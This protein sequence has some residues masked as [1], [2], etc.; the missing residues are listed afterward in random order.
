MLLALTQGK[1]GRIGN[2][3]KAGSSWREVFKSSEDLLTAAVFGRLVYLRGSRLW[4]ILRNAFGSALPDYKLVELVDASFWPTWPE[5]EGGTK[6]VEPDVFLQF[7]VGDPA[8]R[9]DVIVEAKYRPGYDQYAEQWQ[10]QWTAYHRFVAQDDGASA[11]LLAIGGLGPHAATT[12]HRLQGQLRADGLDVKVVAANWPKLLDAV[13]AEIEIA[14]SE[15]RRL[16]GD[17]L[18]AMALAGFR[19]IRQLEDLYSQRRLNPASKSAFLDY[20]YR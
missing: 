16:L 18:E 6:T 3:I 7:N 1:A 13:T 20:D 17:I 8:V 14:K 12:M 5:N 15:E 11:F 4:S 2:E 10:R 19:K 9:I